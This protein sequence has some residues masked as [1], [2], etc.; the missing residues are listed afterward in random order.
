MHSV[1]IP[2]E[3]TSEEAWD[4]QLKREEKDVAVTTYSRIPLSNSASD[5][6]KRLLTAERQL[7][8]NGNYI[9]GSARTSDQLL[10]L[11]GLSRVLLTAEHATDQIRTREDRPIP[12]KEADYGTGALSKVVA[13]DTNSSAI[14]TLGRQTGDAND[15]PAHLFKYAM[16]EI[17]A[18]PENRAHLAMHLLFRGR[19]SQLKAE[20]G[21]SAMLGIGD[22]PSDATK[23]LTDFMIEIGNDLGLKV[24]INRPHFN[25]DD[26]H[27]LMLNDDGTVRSV[28]YAA[29][30]ANTTRTHS[31]NIAEQLGKGDSYAA[32]QVE[33]NEALLVRQD[34]KIEYPTRI[35]RELGAYIGYLFVRKAAES[36]KRL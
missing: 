21:Y 30:G 28:T 6:C 16:T 36:V 9:D 15:D 13:E 35:D 8:P 5:I 10:V 34:N 3:C 25:F 26:A 27:N 2:L 22:K 7:V 20:R 33:L 32:V 23:A 24:D 1:E 14:I 11:R 19:A 31:Q 18:L 17:I 29:R 4:F 12:R